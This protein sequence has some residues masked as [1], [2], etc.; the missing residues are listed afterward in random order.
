MPP[1]LQVEDLRVTYRP[2][3]QAPVAALEGVSL[4][5]HAGE[6][7]AIV[8]ESGSGKSTLAAAIAGLT[9]AGAR[10][11]G[12]ILLDGRPVTG[13]AER[14]WRA[15][16]GRR[17]GY[18]PQEPGLSLDPIQRIGAQ[19]AEALTV[20]GVAAAEAWRRVPEILA[21]VG[22]PDPEGIA[23]KFPHELSGGMRQRV[24]IGIG[25]ANDPPLLIADEPTSGLDVSVQRQVLDHLEGLI[26]RRRVAVLLITHDL[27][28]AAD[29]A[30][31]LLVMRGGRVV[32]AGPVRDVFANPRHPYTAALLAA[33]RPSAPAPRPMP[34]GLPLMIVEGLAKRF[35]AATALD[36]VS[37]AVPRGGTTAIVGESGSGK[38]T[39]ARIMLGLETP[40]AGR[41]RFDGAD[42][43]GLRGA[44]LRG[45]RRR[46]QVVYQNPYASLDPRFTVE[47]TIAEP[48]RAFGLGDRAARRVRVAALMDSVG[49]PARLAGNRPAALSGG[50]RQR[51]AIARA[52]AIGPE[53]V[54]LDEPVSALDAAVQAQIL[55]LLR[56][57]QRQLGVSYLLISHDLAVVREVADHVVVLH[58]GRVVEQGPAEALFERPAE[59]YTRALLG[60]APGQRAA[61]RLALA[62]A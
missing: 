46:V 52:L 41:V 22:L 40:S 48:L 44:A 36:G 31:R 38:T 51:V 45:F 47:Q 9:P 56:D 20:H 19:L 10:L 7:L 3:G 27:G 17:I 29:R 55:A 61:R 13:L 11:E 53:L 58:R 33:A 24:L 39:T 32:E 59:P 49:L 23:Q 5:L 16:R 28:M 4:A 26:Q 62:P 18:V 54:V 6:V 43:A 30:D 1:L 15:L 2:R 50:Q 35:G 12:R 21:E 42:V 34:P 37:F 14:D 8:G 60:D 25:L 57:L